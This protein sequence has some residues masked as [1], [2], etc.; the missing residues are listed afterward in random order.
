MPSVSELEKDATAFTRAKRNQFLEGLEKAI[1]DMEEY[2]SDNID[3]TEDA[4]EL[5]GKKL[6]DVYVYVYFIANHVY[7]K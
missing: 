6:A 4:K 7:M 2:I 3:L 1:G 5:I